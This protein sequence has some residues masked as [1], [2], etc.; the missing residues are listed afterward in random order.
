MRNNPRPRNSHTTLNR[1]RLSKGLTQAQLAEMVGCHARSITYWETGARR[2]DTE[3]L[4]KLAE[5]LEC[6]PAELLEKKEARVS[7]NGEV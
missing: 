3:H 4:L 1:L 7:G 2:P 5:V 6:N